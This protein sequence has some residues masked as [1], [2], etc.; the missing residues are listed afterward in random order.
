MELKITQNQRNEV[1]RR[2][3]VLAEI[4]QEKVPSK[5]EVLKNL[6]AQLNTSVDKIV[7]KKILS[8]YGQQKSIVHANVYD[9]NKDLKNTERKYMLKRNN[10]KEEVV[11]EK[12]TEAQE[13]AS[14]VS[15]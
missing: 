6:S 2:N 15:E 5:E 9:D 3:E 1:L 13:D 4:K 7:V 14:K 8:N 11:S 10:I 12:T